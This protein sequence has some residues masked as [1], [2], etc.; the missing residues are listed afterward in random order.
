MGLRCVFFFKSGESCSKPLC[1]R[2]QAA[3]TAA[4]TSVG[5]RAATSIP[6]IA[7]AP[8]DIT[9]AHLQ[10]PGAAALVPTVV[11][12]DLAGTRRVTLSS[13]NRLSLGKSGEIDSE[14]C[15]YCKENGTRLPKLTL[16]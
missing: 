6:T 7:V 4:A 8:A 12:T 5:L 10:G 2:A 9:T 1:L 11:P 3:G 13:T 16:T 14:W 15:T